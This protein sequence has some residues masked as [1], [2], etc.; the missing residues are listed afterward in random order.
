[1]AGSSV[2]RFPPRF[3]R[4]NLASDDSMILENTSGRMSKLEQIAPLPE[5]TPGGP[6]GSVQMYRLQRM[7]S[8][9]GSKR[10]DSVPLGPAH[11]KLLPTNRASAELEGRQQEIEHLSSGHPAR[12][13]IGRRFFNG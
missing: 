11:S 10:Q 3:T 4:L 13:A 9:K 2:L 7:L 6:D 8:Q 1:M 5:Q 12:A